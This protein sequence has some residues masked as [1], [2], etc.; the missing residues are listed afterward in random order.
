M[1]ISKTKDFFFWIDNFVC[2]RWQK[3]SF[4]REGLKYGFFYAIFLVNI[5]NVSAQILPSEITLLFEDRSLTLNFI[6]QKELLQKQ[7]FHFLRVGDFRF[8]ID[9]EG[10]LAK[11]NEFMDIETE[12]H[13]TISPKKLHEFFQFSSIIRDTEEQKTVEIRFNEDGQIVFEGQPH[14]RFEIEEEKLVHLINQ[15]LRKKNQFVRV[16]AKKIFSNVVVH[17]DLYKRG[18]REIIA[19]GES[20]FT[21]S[22]EARRQNIIAGSQ[23]F[24]GII[25]PKGRRFSF[26][27]ILESVDEESGFVKELVIKGEKTEKELGGGVC[28]VSTTAFRAAFSGGLP[29]DQRRNHSYAVPYYK[30]YGL[31]AAIYLGALDLRFRNDT[32]GDILVQT[33]IEGDNLFFIFYGTNDGRKITLEGP[34]ISHYQQAPKAIVYETEDLPFGEKEEISE[35]HDGFQTEW[36]RKIEKDGKKLHQKFESHYRPWAPKQRIGTKKISKR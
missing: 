27:Q 31:D 16:P 12:F 22:S 4:F 20:N 13:T 19:V 2:Q 11:E 3:M 10:D 18:I 33:F 28:Q 36:I 26:N 9:L 17:P 21:G 14:D 30:P 24:N 6:A 7:P 5:G 25:I 1:N 34:F 23:K 29:I 15:A 35:G 8:P 32:P